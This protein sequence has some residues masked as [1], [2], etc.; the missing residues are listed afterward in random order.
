MK[1]KRVFP[2]VILLGFGLYFLF[3]Q[4]QLE[5]VKNFQTWPVILLITGIAFLFQSYVGHD[6]EEIVPGVILTGFGLHFLIAGRLEF[7]P[8]NIGVFF[9]IIS[10]AFFLR[11]MKLG[12]GLFNGLLFFILS[13][14]FMFHDEIIKRI[15]ILEKGPEY[16][17]Q[18]WPLLL[19]LFG[20]FMFIRRRK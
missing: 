9:L 11:H 8:D 13:I 17:N 3:D 14:F 18:F 5:I 6:Y 15:H 4:L 10:L 19:I 1:K 12:D 7:W 16:V 2:G 20:L